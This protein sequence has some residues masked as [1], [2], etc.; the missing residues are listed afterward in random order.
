VGTIVLADDDPLIRRL[1]Q[2]ALRTFNHTL[3]LAEDG[4]Q[5]WAMIMAHQP[6][7]AILD[8]RMPGQNGWEVLRN[9]RADPAVAHTR[10]LILSAETELPHED[11]L[12]SIHAD[13][14]LV[15]PFSPAVLRTQV[16]ELLASAGP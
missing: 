3:Y 4:E 11:E 1:I 16:A 12:Q 2:A 9:V 10:V 6:D 5:A 15:K 7:L 14:Y 8:V 13:A